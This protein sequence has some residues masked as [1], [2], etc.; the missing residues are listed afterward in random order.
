[1]PKDGSK[2]GPLNGVDPHNFLVG[3][4]DQAGSIHLKRR[5]EKMFEETHGSFFEPF[6][7]NRTDIFNKSNAQRRA[8]SSILHEHSCEC[9]PLPPP[10][11]YKKWIGFQGFS[12]LRWSSNAPSA[13]ASSQKG[14]ITALFARGDH[15]TYFN[16]NFQKFLN[17]VICLD[18]SKRWTTIV[19][20]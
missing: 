9:G 16:G 3:V 2:V 4:P 1:M 17:M 20:G 7:L 8:T 10:N 6:L 13:V 12:I 15:N 19:P 11:L 14:R 18:V 5:L